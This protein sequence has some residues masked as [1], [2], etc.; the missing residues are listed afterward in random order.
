[1]AEIVSIVEIVAEKNDP[2]AIC[3]KIDPYSNYD[4]PSLYFRDIFFQRFN[5][6]FAGYS[7]Y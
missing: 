1:M 3:C 5:L 6:Q 2:G 7:L 4:V